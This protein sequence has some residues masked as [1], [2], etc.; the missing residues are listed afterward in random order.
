MPNQDQHAILLLTAHFGGATKGDPRPLGPKEW[1]EFAQWLRAEGHRPGDL[2]NG[3]A[4]QLIAN[5]NHRK[6]TTER[7][8]FLLAR[9]SAMALALEKWERAGI[10]VLTRGD[11]NYP[12]R[13]KQRLGSSAPPVFFGCGNQRLLNQGGVAFVGSRKATDEHLSFTR[14]ASKVVAAAGQS[15]VSGGARGVDET[16]MLAALEDEGTVIGVLGDSLLRAVSSSKYRKALRRGDLVLI[17]PYQPEARFQVGNAM[18][19]NKY[20]YCLSDAAVVVTCE[21]GS[22]GTWAGATEALKHRWVPVWT[23][24]GEVEGNGL[25]ALEAMGAGR[26]SPDS[27]LRVAAL[28]EGHSTLDVAPDAKPEAPIAIKPQ[29]AQVESEEAAPYM[30]P[31]RETTTDPAEALF[32]AFLEQ[33]QLMI[34]TE[35]MKPDEIAQRLQI[36]PVQARDWLQKAEKAGLI[37]KVS[38]KPAAYAWASQGR[39]ILGDG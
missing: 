5:W 11:E 33:L 15:V 36:K 12:T 22:G 35:P 32:N 26:L 3:A 6:I 28:F 7:L 8:R 19:R 31:N 38:K 27:D 23:Y 18:G 39:L 25:A 37:D 1:G 9:G 29:S 20:I 13:L 24:R 4:D 14:K 10:W 2:V 17:S 16:A 21:E 34:Q 30:T